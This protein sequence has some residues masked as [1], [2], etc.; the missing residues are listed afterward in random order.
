MEGDAAGEWTDAPDDDDDDDDEGEETLDPPEEEAVVPLVSSG[1]QGM[2]GIVVV[3]VSTKEDSP[4]L[5][6]IA[7]D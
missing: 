1:N 4:L 5:S 2:V 7:D 3:A 6:G